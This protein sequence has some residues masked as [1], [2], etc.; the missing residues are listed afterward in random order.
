MTIT[1][2]DDIKAKLQCHRYSSPTCVKRISSSAAAVARKNMVLALEMVVPITIMGHV[3]TDPVVI[4]DD[5]TKM[6][7]MKVSYF[8][9]N[10][11]FC[12][13]VLLSFS[14]AD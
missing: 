9:F 14:V 13:I 6:T 1:A 2:I 12:V 8:F 7:L 5:A 10:Y 4:E 3:T 11:W